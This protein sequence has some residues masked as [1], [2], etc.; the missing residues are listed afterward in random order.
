VLAGLITQGAHEVGAAVG[1]LIPAQ[2]GAAEVNLAVF[3]KSIGLDSTGAVAVALDVQLA[4]LLWVLVG[5]AVALFTSPAE[6][7]DEAAS[8]KLEL[9]G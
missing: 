3:A 7:I 6:T 4:Q 5:L 8:P 1:G 9:P 2:I